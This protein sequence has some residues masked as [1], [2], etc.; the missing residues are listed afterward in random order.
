[1]VPLP[2]TY[3]DDAVLVCIVCLNIM[4]SKKPIDT[5]KIW[6]LTTGNPRQ[7]QNILGV[8][9]GTVMIVIWVIVGIL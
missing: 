3:K 6:Y 9:K 4:C 2:W 8:L 5:I 1:M 7:Q